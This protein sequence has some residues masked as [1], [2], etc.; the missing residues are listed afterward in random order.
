MVVVVSS[1]RVSGFRL[2]AEAAEEDLEE[3]SIERDDF[4]MGRC[5]E[6]HRYSFVCRTNYWLQK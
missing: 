6:E 1:G 3:A 5:S 4:S 2:A